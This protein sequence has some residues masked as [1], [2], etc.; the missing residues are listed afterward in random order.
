MHN[1]SDTHSS[2]APKVW[3]LTEKSLKEKMS[4]TKFKNKIKIW[5]TSQC[6][7]QL[8]KKYIGSIGFIY[9]GSVISGVTG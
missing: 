7:C 8:C 4:V 2:L 3:K 1:G 9:N 5:T 6:P